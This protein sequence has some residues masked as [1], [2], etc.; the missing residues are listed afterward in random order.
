V[1]V[2]TEFHP[3]FLAD[4]YQAASE[5]NKC[6]LCQAVCPTYVTNP[7]EWE[8]ARGRVGLVRDAIEGLIELRDIADGPL[9]T[10]LTCDN[11]VA[12]CAPRVPTAHIVSRARQELHEQEGHP[13]A[14]TLGLRSVLPHPGVLGALHRLARIAQVT[15]VDRVLRATGVLHWLGTPGALAEQA[16]PLPARTAYR[17]SRDLPLAAEPVRGRLGFL[18]CC[19]ANLAAP[20]AT[21]ATMRVLLAN[22]Y[23]LVVPVLGCSGLPAR[24]LGDREA[25][26][27][28]A[29]R[30]LS[31]LQDLQVDAYVGDVAS[32]TQHYRE[33]ADFAGDD[34][35]V[36]E[37]ARAVSARTSLAT[38][39]LDREGLRVPLGPLRWN[40]T[41]D[42]PCSLPIDGPERGAM[43]RILRQV[44][45]LR[46]T[47]MNE[48]AMCCAG[49]GTYFARQPERSDSILRRKFD[50]IRATG[51]DVV[52]TENISCLLQLRAGAKRYAPQVRVLHVMQVLAES[53]LVEERRRAVLPE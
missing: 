34:R 14:Q 22:G 24:T 40:V 12:A 42:E 7:V 29:V 39:L 21:E 31:T 8:T 27:D 17:R 28:M 35:L 2:T 45:R 26:V 36:G 5:C 6:S 49:A 44:P 48:A 33:Y 37:R 25:M 13:W 15:G 30:N 43:R 18:V 38:D 23:E 50:N 1:A 53:M 9:S 51:A 16:G 10:C 47:E 52:V 41:V 4:V 11:C 19:Y 20:D 32:C 46:I 3:R